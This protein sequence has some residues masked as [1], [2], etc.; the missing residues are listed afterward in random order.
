MATCQYPKGNYRKE[1][2]RFFSRVCGD[3]TRGNGLK[4]KESRFR[5]NIRKRYFTVK[6]VRQWNR[7]P[8]VVVD[9][10]VPGDFQSEAG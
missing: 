9:V 1:G 6:V 4:L 5:L 10:S 7:L 8:S 3:R 2:D